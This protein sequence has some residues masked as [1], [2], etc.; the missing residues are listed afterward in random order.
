MGWDAGWG[1]VAWGCGGS[2][3]N[4]DPHNIYAFS[5]ERMKGFLSKSIFDLMQ[6]K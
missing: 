1:G 3:L 6:V 4:I 5:H 2:F